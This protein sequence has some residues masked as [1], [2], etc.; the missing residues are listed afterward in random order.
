MADGVRI[1]VEADTISPALARLRALAGDLTP[2][3]DEIGDQLVD[4]VL[5]R[6]RRGVGPDGQAWPVSQRAE[7]EGGQTLVD[8]GRLRESIVSEAGPSSVTVGTNVLYARIHQLGG[9]IRPKTA[10]RLRFR[11]AD[12]QFVAVDSVTLP[13]RP[14]LGIGA[15][16]ASD[17]EN[18]A[19]RRIAEITRARA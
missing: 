9:T 13:A 5:E 18:I 12:G 6:F 4:N 10:D 2:V 15:E 17:I 7:E 16:D 19:L 11:L 14:Y 1:R 3:L 8:S